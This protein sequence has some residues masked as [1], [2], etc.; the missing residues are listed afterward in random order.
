MKRLWVGLLLVVTTLS[1]SA[2]Q[3]ELKLL[4]LQALKSPSGSAKSE[5]LG[6]YAEV[7]RAKTQRPDARVFAEVT[8]VAT[9]KQQECKRI[10]VRI[11]TPGTLLPTS[12]GSS[13]MLDMNAQMNMC[14]NGRPPDTEEFASKK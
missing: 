8:T 5:I 6:P 1:A 4:A 3:N 13:R 7:I 9:F 10:N 2:D 14:P 12:D 11:F